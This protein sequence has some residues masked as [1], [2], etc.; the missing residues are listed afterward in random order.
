MTDAEKIEALREA[1][2]DAIAE[3]DEWSIEL[4]GE[5]FNSPAWNQLL[6]DTDDSDWQPSKRGSDHY[7]LTGTRGLSA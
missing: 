1:L 2:K 7:G 3:L 5:G 4:T 6:K